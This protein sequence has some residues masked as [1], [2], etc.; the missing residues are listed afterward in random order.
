M[1]IALF[2]LVNNLAG[3]N[4]LVDKI[5]IFI[6]VY[7]PLLYGA[8]MIIQW[9]IGGDYGKKASMNAFFSAVIALGINLIIST[10]YF[11]PR[12]FVSHKV[13]LL[14][15][16]PNDA[17]FP[18]DHASGGSSLTFAEIKYDKI[19]GS[20]MMVM[21][22]ILLFARVYVGVHYPFDVIGGFVI[23]FISSRLVNRL[24]I[25]INPIEKFILSMWHK[26]ATN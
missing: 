3:Q 2:H 1:N 22:I 15:K 25:V 7:S 26:L 17:S 16:H 4:R 13:N 10:F 6:A 14:V 5:M 20:V 12:P 24:D 19:I 9:F 11:E 23:G 21:T 8:L 18:S